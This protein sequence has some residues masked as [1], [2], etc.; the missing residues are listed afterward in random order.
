[1]PLVTA[2]CPECGGLIEVNSELKAANC[3]HC[4]A[5]F[6]IEDA[7][8]NYN[9]YISHNYNTT[10]NYGDGT[11][12]NIVEGETKETLLKNAE[13]ALR[14]ENYTLSKELFEFIN[15]RYP[16]EYQGWWGLLQSYTEGFKSF[17]VTMSNINS[18]YNYTVK[19][20]PKEVVSDIE[21]NFKDYLYKRSL[22]ETNNENRLFESIKNGFQGQ[23]AELDTQLNNSYNS[24]NKTLSYKNTRIA[25][26]NKRLEEEDTK[27]C[28]YEKRLNARQQKVK[29]FVGFAIVVVLGLIFIISSVKNNGESEFLLLLAVVFGFGGFIGLIVDAVLFFKILDDNSTSS[30]DSWIS[31]CQSDISQ[32]KKEKSRIESEIERTKQTQNNYKEQINRKKEELIQLVELINSYL[33]LDTEEKAN[34]IFYD[35]CTNVGI[36]VEKNKVVY[37]LRSRVMG[38]QTSNPDKSIVNTQ[39]N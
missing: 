15:K 33:N 18:Y 31:G 32:L 35:L 39:I 25:E 22:Y 36:V 12:V 3:Q 28:E 26:L 17:D 21:K 16:D 20:C 11:I 1:M 2:K 5:P 8:N 6:V 30:Y 29:V 7:I 34:S 14:I 13:T 23:I 37:E 19:L 4:G 38:L 24:N 10:N 27:K 9:T